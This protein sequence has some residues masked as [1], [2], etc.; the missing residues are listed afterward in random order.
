MRT[1]ATV[2]GLTSTATAIA[3][4]VQPGPASPWLALSR[5]RAWVSALAGATPCPIR[6][7]SRARSSSERTTMCRLRT[8]ASCSGGIP[9]PHEHETEPHISQVTTDELLVEVP[10]AEVLVLSEADVTALLDVDELLAALADAFRALSAGRSSVPPRVAAHAEAGL[11]GAMPVHLSG[12]A[13]GAKLVAVFPGNHAAGRPSHQ[14]LIALFDEA[15]GTPLAVMDAARI[16]ALRT[17]AAAA[18]AAGALA[19]PDA[20]VL[21]ILGAGVQGHSHLE[22]FP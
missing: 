5:M 7:W 3:A 10:M 19:R 2:A 17:G 13:L 12:V 21:A 18:V 4:S 8:S 9:R 11:L 6:V 16:T 14:G 20:A 15:D 1:R 22:T